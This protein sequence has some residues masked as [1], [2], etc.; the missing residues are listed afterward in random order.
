MTLATLTSF[1]Q[2]SWGFMRSSVVG[3]QPGRA[4]V[5]FTNV[6]SVS[7]SRLLSEYE[8]LLSD[9]ER[10]R[11]QA[12]HFARD[13]HLYLVAHGLLRTSLSRYADVQPQSWTFSS[14]ELG[15][16]EIDS[17]APHSDRIRFNLA[18]TGGLAAC[19]IARNVD[20]GIDVECL[21]RRVDSASLAPRYFSQYETQQL[22]ELSGAERETRFLEYWTLKE[23]YVKALGGG[24]S[25]PLD[26]FY[27]CRDQA[28]EWRI[29]F[30]AEASHPDDWQFAC[31]RPTPKHVMSIAIHRRNKLDYEIDVGE[32]LPLSATF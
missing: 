28:G 30:D 1:T 3:L 23:A 5:W 11:H 21:D 9:E 14:E 6:N 17:I 26:D 27:F 18:H 12:F 13:R 29:A 24:L 25:I 32:A 16:P 15:R 8:S 20:V 4:V 19:V 10:K 7:D 31:L 22:A 2:V